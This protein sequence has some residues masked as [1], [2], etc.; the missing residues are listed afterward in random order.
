[1]G[2]STSRCLIA[3]GAGHSCIERM[4]SA[5][6]YRSQLAI[7]ITKVDVVEQ[8]W[9][10]ARAGSAQANGAPFQLFPEPD[11][12][13]PWHIGGA[14]LFT[15]QRYSQLNA[16]IRALQHV[17]FKSDIAP[18]ELLIDH[19]RLPIRGCETLTEQSLR[20]VQRANLHIED[21]LRALISYETA[22]SEHIRI[23]RHYIRKFSKMLAD[24][25]M[26]SLFQKTECITELE[27]RV[28]CGSP[29]TEEDFAAMQSELAA[30]KAV[31]PPIW[32][33]FRGRMS[34]EWLGL[35]WRVS[36]LGIQIPRQRLIHEFM[37]VTI[38]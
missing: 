18:L 5:S 29:D 31:A 22:I 2:S 34:F 20:T 3:I 13:M 26:D 36:I 23:I 10:G 33:A 6:W 1:M 24:N 28:D 12:A 15:H 17:G 30:W 8:R 37:D 14:L 25:A 7:L 32:E 21:N 38:R 27:W 16:R 19:Y 35:L 11:A 9:T 4:P